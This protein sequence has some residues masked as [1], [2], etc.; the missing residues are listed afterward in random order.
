MCFFYVQFRQVAGIVLMNVPFALIGGILVYLRESTSVSQ[1]GCFM[2][3]R[4]VRPK[5]G[6]LV[7]VF[8]KNVDLRMHLDDAILNGRFPVRPV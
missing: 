7:S 3:F 4:R 1:Q 6:I 8:N 2:P 5:R